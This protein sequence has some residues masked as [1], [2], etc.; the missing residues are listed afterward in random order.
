MNHEAIPESEDV[1]NRFKEVTLFK[2]AKRFTPEADKRHYVFPSPVPG[3]NLYA[4]GKSAAR[5]NSQ[6]RA[7]GP[8]EF[9]G[10]QVASRGG[11][12]SG[13]MV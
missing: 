5:V 2:S 3:I 11:K 8:H 10:P 12:T 13:V 6:T 7:N 9:A 4:N 1:E